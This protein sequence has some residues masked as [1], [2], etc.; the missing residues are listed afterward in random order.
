MVTEKRL[1]AFVDK[2]EGDTATLLIGDEGRPVCWP[3]EALPDDVV[4]GSII[5]IILAL[6]D[7]ATKAA[8]DVINSLIDRLE[9]KD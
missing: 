6:D 3:V 2:I 9:H 5:S 8:E 4:E 1:R 7:D